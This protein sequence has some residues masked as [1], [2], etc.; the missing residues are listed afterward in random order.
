MY[1]LWCRVRRSG[2][3]SRITPNMR[4]EHAAVRERG[5]TW[6]DLGNLHYSNDPAEDAAT[7]LDLM[8][9]HL[10]NSTWLCTL[11]HAE[12]RGRVAV[13]SG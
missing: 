7:V 10:L 2:L 8:T 4:L 6:E 9:R 12:A 11:V 13:E 5:K 1:F 3:K